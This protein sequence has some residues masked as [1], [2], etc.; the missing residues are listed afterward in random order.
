MRA[1]HSSQ[2]HIYA[3]T[4]KRCKELVGQASLLASVS[5]LSVCDARMGKGGGAAKHR[6]QTAQCG[7]GGVVRDMLRNQKLEHR[8]MGR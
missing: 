2:S 8:V 1:L 3:G 4:E 7:N 5:V 6:A